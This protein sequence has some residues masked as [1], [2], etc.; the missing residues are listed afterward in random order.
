[1]NK[2]NVILPLPDVLLI[3]GLGWTLHEIGISLAICGTLFLP[4]TFLFPLVSSVRW[5]L[6]VGRRGMSTQYVFLITVG[7][8]IW[9]GDSLPNERNCCH[10][11][12]ARTAQCSLCLTRHPV[13]TAKYSCYTLLHVYLTLWPIRNPLRW[14]LVILGL[15]IIRVTFGNVLVA[16]ALFINNSVT[17]D[18]LGEVNG[19]AHS[20]T[21]IVR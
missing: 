18:K 11:V 9:S 4:F 3:G 8:E 2:Y 5:Y 19:L 15:V 12:H 7:E 16:C 17:F 14:F 6:A 20:L 1:M 10:C 13:S 21:S